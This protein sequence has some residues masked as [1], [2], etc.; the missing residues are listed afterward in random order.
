MYN[1]QCTAQ[2]V[3][4]CDRCGKRRGV[5]RSADREA[6]DT[7]R[8]ESNLGVLDENVCAVLSVCACCICVRTRLA[9]LRPSCVV[10]TLFK[11]LLRGLWR[12]AQASPARARDVR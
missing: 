12:A 2:H 6:N 11:S 3:A 7:A 1:A 5:K 10:A 9:S 4:R 8:T